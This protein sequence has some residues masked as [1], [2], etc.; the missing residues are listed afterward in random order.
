M[1]DFARDSLLEDFYNT[2]VFSSIWSYYIYNCKIA[3]YYRICKISFIFI[4]LTIIS[5]NIALIFD[6]L[7]VRDAANS[8]SGNVSRMSMHKSFGA[9]GYGYAQALMLLIPLLAYHIKHDQRIY[10][11]KKGLFVIL[12]LVVITTLRAQVFANM[13]VM[14]IILF[15]SFTNIKKRKAMYKYVFIIMFI[16]ML[17]PKT[18]Y[19][20]LLHSVSNY[21]PNES[22]T[23]FKLNDL[24]T[25]LENPEMDSSTGAGGRASRYPML[26]NAFVD[27]P[28]FG[29]AS[30]DSKHHIGGGF[31]IFWMYRLTLWG[32]FGFY[33]Y[34]FILY[35]IYKSISKMI[36]DEE[37]KS[38]YFLSVLTLI[39]L[40]LLKNIAGRE[41]WIFII[42]VIPGLYMGIL[43]QTQSKRT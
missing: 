37:M 24:A 20:D 10:F 18:F 34:L 38:Y 17:I 41:P 33:Y 31:H 4:T 1:S 14:M 13:L 3:N 5:T 22:N 43:N 42:I 8:F 40:G 30:Y 9:A 36:Y 7:I 2:L 35:I 12:I 29:D 23:Y 6:P 21:F 25:F 16:I 26:F 19:I 28:L 39:L 11:T 27:S 15:L 32:I